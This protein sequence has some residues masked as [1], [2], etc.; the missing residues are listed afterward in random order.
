MQL[1]LSLSLS[2]VSVFLLVRGSGQAVTLAFDTLWW[3]LYLMAHTFDGTIIWVRIHDG[4]IILLLWLS[5]NFDIQIQVRP[6]FLSQITSG[7]ISM[8]HVVSFYCLSLKYYASCGDESHLWDLVRCLYNCAVVKWPFFMVGELELNEVICLT[9]LNWS[10]QYLICVSY[11][12]E[13]FISW[14]DSTR[15]AQQPNISV[16]ADSPR[17]EKHYSIHLDWIIV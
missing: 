6:E 16:Q 7:N 8:G 12:F 3:H 1:S 11:P 9:W 17:G 14:Q 4:T 13:I 15:A 5:S 2:S 10:L